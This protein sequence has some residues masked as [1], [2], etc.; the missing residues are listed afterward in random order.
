MTYC[1]IKKL[2]LLTDTKQ[3]YYNYY[4]SLSVIKGYDNIIWQ[5]DLVSGLCP[6]CH[7]KKHNVLGTASTPVLRWKGRKVPTQL[8]V[9]QWAALEHWTNSIQHNFSGIV[10]HKYAVTSYL[11]TNLFARDPTS[12]LLL[13]TRAYSV[14]NLPPFHRAPSSRLHMLLPDWPVYFFCHPLIRHTHPIQ[15]NPDP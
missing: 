8:D 5:S 11:T 4:Y 15:R 10:I 7:T 12:A 9:T 14:L 6:L 3:K 13:L 1:K 2:H